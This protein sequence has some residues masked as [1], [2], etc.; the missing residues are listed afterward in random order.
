[1]R[2]TN[3][4]NFYNTID[5]VLAN[6]QEYDELIVR[7]A[8]ID[9]AKSEG[10]KRLEYLHIY[11]EVIQYSVNR[12]NYKTAIYSLGILGGEESVE[13]IVS[14]YARFN[15]H[16]I[17]DYSLQRNYR[18]IISMLDM[19]NSKNTILMGIKA[20]KLGRIQPAMNAL[21]YIAKN[22]RD[23]ELVNKSIEAISY[24]YNNPTIDN[25]NKWED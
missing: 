21:Q 14:N 3:D 5:I 20:S 19:S 2:R 18:V 13:V 23:E 11:D 8:L 1:M 24:L 6:H 7:H 10:T 15:N 22:S 16:Y 12:A 9:N 25:F 17:E 4:I